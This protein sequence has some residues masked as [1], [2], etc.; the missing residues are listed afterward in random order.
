MKITSVASQVKELILG[1]KNIL[2]VTHKEPNPD[3]IGAILGIKKALQSFKKNPTLL[4]E[5][6]KLEEYNFFPDIGQIKNQAPRKTLTVVID[7]EDVPISKI[8]YESKNNKLFLTF[9][10]FSGTFDLEHINYSLSNL[11]YDLAIVLD[12]PEFSYL[13]EIANEHHEDLE[14]IPLI[15][16]DFHPQNSL[17]GKINYVDSNACSTCEVTFSFLEN[18]GV[19]ITESIAQNL[20]MGILFRTNKLQKNLT[21]NCLRSIAK[22]IETGAN[23]EEI[24]AQLTLPLKNSNS[25]VKKQKDEKGPTKELVVEPHLS[26]QNN[27]A[28]YTQIPTQNKLLQFNKFDYI[29]TLKE[30]GLTKTE[31]ENQITKKSREESK[32][33]KKL[34]EKQKEE[35][36]PST[37]QPWNTKNED[38][39]LR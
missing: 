10:P 5:N 34:N 29:P 3:G 11:N 31:D 25:V 37:P 2:L 36:A 38:G 32:N 20:L 22:L 33:K 9:T 30:A 16:I 18:L 8:N 39:L 27:T 4:A 28:T 24:S 14:K 7:Y 15:N 26:P 23:L 21:A 19:E 17:F 6:L 35:V 12:T 13:G 1:A